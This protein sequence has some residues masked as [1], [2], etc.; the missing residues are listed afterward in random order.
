M[1]AVIYVTAAGSAIDSKALSIILK[2]KV[3]ADHEPD[4]S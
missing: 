3:S 4:F 2:R 1:S